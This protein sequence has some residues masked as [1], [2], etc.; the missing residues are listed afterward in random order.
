MT[1]TEKARKIF[2]ILSSICLDQC[3]C[4]NDHECRF[5]RKLE[6]ARQI[7]TGDNE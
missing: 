6:R 3:Y 2:D 1:D 7:L 4:D 5:C